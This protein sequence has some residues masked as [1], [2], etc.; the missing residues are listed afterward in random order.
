MRLKIIEHFLVFGSL[1]HLI[2]REP[3]SLR[4]QLSCGR[5]IKPLLRLHKF[6]LAEGAG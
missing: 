1:V 2:E 6:A 3:M 4:G 5:L